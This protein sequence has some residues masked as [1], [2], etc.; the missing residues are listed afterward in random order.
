MRAPLKKRI[1]LE[2][3]R[4]PMMR[5]EGMSIPLRNGSIE[6]PLGFVEILHHVGGKMNLRC[7]ELAVWLVEF[8]GKAV[9][10][11]VERHAGVGLD[12]LVRGLEHG[13]GQLGNASRKNKL[14]G[15]FGP[16]LGTFACPHS[17]QSISKKAN[18]WSD[19][20]KMGKTQKEGVND[21]SVFGILGIK[22]GAATRTWSPGLGLQPASSTSREMKRALNL[23]KD[24]DGPGAAGD[25]VF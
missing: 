1:M 16:L 4:I 6:E 11:F 18:L 19:E 8:C 15:P 14:L 2:N 13:I 24:S 3:D 10:Q 9:D 17:H 20:P 23:R 12:M 22:S 7:G 25:A 5:W 21:G